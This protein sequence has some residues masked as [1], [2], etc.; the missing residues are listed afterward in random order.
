MPEATIWLM[1]QGVLGVVSALFIY[2]YLSERTAKNK[3]A[4]ECE[5]ELKDQ[6]EKYCSD[7]DNVRQA[8]ITRERELAK[9]LED[10]GRSVLDAVEQADFL[11]K[12]LRRM[13]ER[14]ER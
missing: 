14:R 11:S 3:A 8:Q 2:L 7:L 6:R 10:Y 1:T 12:E 4:K 13:Y 5:K 9:T